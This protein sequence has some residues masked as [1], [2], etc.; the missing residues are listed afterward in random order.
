MH[1]NEFAA[2]LRQ[3]RAE[4]GISERAEKA[5]DSGG[6]EHQQHHGRS[7]H[8]LQHDARNHENRGPD[9]GACRHRCGAEHPQPFTNSV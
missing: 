2:R 3:R 9:H 4:F 6:H 1:I 5:E 7:A 8:L